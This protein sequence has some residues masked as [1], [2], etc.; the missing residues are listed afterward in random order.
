M[1]DGEKPFLAER[2]VQ[3]TEHREYG[4]GRPEQSFPRVRVENL[5]KG[6]HASVI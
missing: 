6:L 4:V 3:D 1:T 2:R 5:G